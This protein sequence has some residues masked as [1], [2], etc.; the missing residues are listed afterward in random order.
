MV[1]SVL[2]YMMYLQKWNFRV[3][4]LKICGSFCAGFVVKMQLE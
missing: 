4:V 3:E 1:C 2:I